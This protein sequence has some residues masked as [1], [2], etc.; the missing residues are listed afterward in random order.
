[1]E[2]FLCSSVKWEAR[3][4]GTYYMQVLYMPTNAIKGNGLDG[5]TKGYGG[6]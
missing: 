2:V 4:L 5:Y 1:M 6:V 3:Y